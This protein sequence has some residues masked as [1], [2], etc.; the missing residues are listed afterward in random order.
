MSARVTVTA[1][2]R[3][4]RTTYPP[5]TRIAFAWMAGI[6]ALPFAGILFYA[7]KT[8]FG[9]FA[10]VGADLNSISWTWAP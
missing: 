8:M 7:A 9:V 2:H 1:R 5:L 4:E 6:A 10:G 3:A